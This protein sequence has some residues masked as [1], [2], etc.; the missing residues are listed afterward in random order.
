MASDPNPTPPS[1]APGQALGRVVGTLFL[2]TL[3]AP[4]VVQLGADVLRPMVAAW[5]SGGALAARWRAASHTAAAR[6]GQLGSTFEDAGVVSSNL[7]PWV[8][9]ALT[10]GLGTGNERV[11]VG[12]HGWL[13]RRPEVARLIAVGASAEPRP[14]TEDDAG[15]PP[16]PHPDPL[17]A[18][19]DFAR[20]LHA[21]GITLVLMPAP[22]KALL[23]AGELSARLR[24]APALVDRSLL[25]L[26]DA[27]PREGVL[28]FDPAP[29]LWDA[30]RRAARSLFLSGDTHW[31]PEGMALVARE[32]ARFVNAKIVLPPAADP[33]YHLEET[34]VAGTGD[35]TAM[36][37]FPARAAFR[38]ERV[39]VQQVLDGFDE[40][41][42]PAASGDVLLLGDSFA[43]IYSYGAMGWGESAGLAEHL[44]FELRR[45]LDVITRNGEGSWA[46]RSALS[47]ELAKG[48]D[49]LAGKRVVI[50]EFAARQV[51]LGDWPLLPMVVGAPPPRRFVVPSAGSTVTVTGTIAEMAPVPRPRTAPYADYVV[52]IHLVDVVA[53]TVAGKANEALVFMWAMRDRALTPA[54]HFRVGQSVTLRLRP[55]AEVAEQVGY[56]SRGEL[57]EGGLMLEEPCWGEETAP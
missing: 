43:N 24:G 53:P 7:R 30:Q 33:R 21:R 13:F 9:A 4:V 41:W 3:L 18:V 1:S 35:L 55:W 40:L 54:A 2:A 51:G 23:C 38:P 34:T 17:P 26:E 5:E 31:R 27:A 22:G 52:G 11:L 32:L 44:A 50:W 28:V 6:V 46:T 15:G 36:L 42:R 25:R 8:Q 12:L 14:A 20:Q 45:P 56:A 49:R 57:L 19:L 29:V 37:G 39:T 10:R 48:R 16:P 47:Q